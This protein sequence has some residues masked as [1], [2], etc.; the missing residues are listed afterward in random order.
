MYSLIN[1][2]NMPMHLLVV[3]CLGADGFWQ[4]QEPAH[5]PRH[6]RGCYGYQC[7]GVFLVLNSYSGLSSSKCR[8]CHSTINKN[9][10][11]VEILIKQLVI[12]GYD[13]EK[14]RRYYGNFHSCHATLKCLRQHTAGFHKQVHN[15]TLK[16]VKVH[17]WPLECL[18][19]TLQCMVYV[20]CSQRIATLRTTV[21]WNGRNNF[22]IRA[23]IDFEW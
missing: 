10:A 20:W 23:L 18:T 7:G 14:N 9:E 8:S 12:N 4:V 5:S 17:H 3:Y 21:I 13:V 15:T 22:S 6:A 2:A 16:S 11:R 19:L 1:V